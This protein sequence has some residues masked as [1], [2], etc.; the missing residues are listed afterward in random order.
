[1]EY[2]EYRWIEDTKEY[3]AVFRTQEDNQEEAVLLKWPRGAKKAVIPS[4]VENKR[5]VKI[6]PLAFAE[7]HLQ[8]N[9]MDA[10]YFENPVSFSTF[11]MKNGKYMEYEENAE[12][13]PHEVEIPDSVTEIGEFAFFGCTCL[14]K[15]ILPKSLLRI[16]A[17]AFSGCS[18]LKELILS[19][20]IRSI[21]YFPE[22]ETKQCMPDIGVF[23][24]C[25][26]LKEL[27]IPESLREIGAETFNG[28]GICRIYVIDAGEGVWSEKRKVHRT[29]FD[30]TAAL[31]HLA[32]VDRL[33]R[34]QWMIGL[35]IEK[36]K[37]L[38]SDKTFG[39]IHSIP[40][41]FFEQLPRE[42][43]Q[44]AVT[45]FRIDFSGQ[46]AVSRLQYPDYL[47]ADMQIWYI[48]ILV[49]YFERLGKFGVTNEMGLT[50]IFNLLSHQPL[51]QRKHISR[52]LRKAENAE[53]SL[54]L[55]E[56]MIQLR[57]ERFAEDS[58]FEELEW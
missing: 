28:C 52:L 24:G 46:M 6:A 51:L 41:Y 19:E 29:A 35:P 4:F 30:H 33:C 7:F 3:T 36:D 20:N 25:A 10:L 1:M 12:E 47:D 54:E 48:E 57:N 27:M 26:A 40:T 49:E 15:I 58:G 55:A 45:L 39:K 11:Q 13:G 50:G 21:G 9:R 23:N 56:K 38:N 32:K 2:M 34:I 53:I 8:P 37:I 5:V 17:G 43:D 14:K 16:Q 42:L 18:Q 31:Q 22:S 44:L